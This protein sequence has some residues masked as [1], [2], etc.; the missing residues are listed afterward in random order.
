MKNG[1]SVGT[2]CAAAEKRRNADAMNSFMMRDL[3]VW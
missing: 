1:G 2:T 3:L